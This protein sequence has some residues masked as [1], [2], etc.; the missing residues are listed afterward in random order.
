[1]PS[2][3]RFTRVKRPFSFFMGTK[4]L[5]K[6]QL[7]ILAVIFSTLTFCRAQAAVFEAQS[8][9]E[10]I[11][12]ERTQRQ[13]EP[14]KISDELSGAAAEKAH[15][16]FE[17]GYFAHNSP[18]GVTPWHWIDENGYNYAVAGENLAIN[19]ADAQAQHAAF[20]ASQSHR[21][22]ILN[23][24]YQDVGIAV[25]E[26]TMH[27]RKTIITVQEF[28]SLS[29]ATAPSKKP[30]ENEKAKSSVPAEPAVGGIK[31]QLQARLGGPADYGVAAGTLA[32]L[33]SI[34]L[35]IGH[36]HALAQSISVWRRRIRRAFTDVDDRYPEHSACS[37]VD[38][39]H[40]G[41]IYLTHMKLRK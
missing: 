15:D 22:N 9:V 10:L 20:M 23:S 26:G 8:V 27:G 33:G 41:K 28:G 18:Q 36:A 13:L 30:A 1:M 25:V 2:K 16:M 5:S 21:D 40:F 17:K 4:R 35:L 34:I 6:V 19:F 11:N 7:V 24:K 29:V 37:F 3:G 32:F 14:L 12:Q 31:T 39:I 38:S